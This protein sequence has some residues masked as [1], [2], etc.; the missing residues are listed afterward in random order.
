MTYLTITGLT[1]RA[2]FPFLDSLGD[3]NIGVVALVAN[4]AVLVAVSLATRTSNIGGE[5]GRRVS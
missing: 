1:L 4:T 2:M 5:A 3:I